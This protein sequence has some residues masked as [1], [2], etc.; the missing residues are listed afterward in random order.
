[1]AN[2][3]SMMTREYIDKSSSMVCALNA[4][5]LSGFV[6]SNLGSNFLFTEEVIADGRR[7]EAKIN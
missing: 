1:M 3:N 4:A 2:L 5:V 6:Q 7:L